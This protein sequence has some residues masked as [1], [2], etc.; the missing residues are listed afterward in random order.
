LAAHGASKENIFTDLHF[1]RN[2]LYYFKN[3]CLP[4]AQAANFPFFGERHGLLY[5]AKVVGGVEIKIRLEGGAEKK[6]K[7]AARPETRRVPA[8]TGIKTHLATQGEGVKKILAEIEQMVGLA[9][10]KAVIF[11]VQAF[12]EIQ[13]RRAGLRLLTEPTVL[14]SLFIGNP[15]TGKTT[16]ARH[17][18]LLYK[19]MG[20]LNRGHMLEVERADLVGEYIGHTAQK[21]KDVVKKALGGVLFI[22]EAYSLSRGGEKDFG[23][24]AIDVLVKAMEDYKNDFILILAG[25]TGEMK[26]FLQSNP[27]LESRFPLH[28]AF[29][30]YSLPELML[31]A[32]HMYKRRQYTLSPEGQKALEKELCRILL[33]YP[34]T[35]GNARLVRNVVEGSL[36]MQAVRLMDMENNKEMGSEELQLITACDAQKALAKVKLVKERKAQIKRLYVQ[37]GGGNE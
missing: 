36:R 25:Y 23:R 33:E 7:E 3:P 30:D 32:G 17:L 12:A 16:M 35:H 9:E 19:E 22:D 8:F 37:A 6:A 1:S 2:F 28:I 18:A 34:Q 11:E 5:R 4:A 26:D 10:V 29:P 13:K 24:E 27:G 31:I 21:T 20:L 15:G 14:H